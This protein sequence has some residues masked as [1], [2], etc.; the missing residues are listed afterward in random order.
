MLVDALL[1]HTCTL[2]VKLDVPTY[3]QDPIPAHMRRAVLITYIVVRL[4]CLYQ[5]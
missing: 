4:R 2:V 3:V 5:F 1:A